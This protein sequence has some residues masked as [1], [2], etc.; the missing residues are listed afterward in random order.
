M[1]A[2]K[3]GRYPIFLDKE[4]HLLISLNV[5]D[6][7]QDRFGGYDDLPKYLKG[8]DSIKNLKW[9]LTLA[10]NEGR[11]PDEDEL[12]EQEVG[13]LIHTG[14]MREMTASIYK[15]FGMAVNGR[16]EADPDETTEAGEDQISFQD[17]D[18]LND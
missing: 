12:S 6:A 7:I 4:R 5:I 11:A 16:A 13:R 9:L 8:K 17:A 3:D 14:N 15:A 18:K 1:S 10:I 2:I